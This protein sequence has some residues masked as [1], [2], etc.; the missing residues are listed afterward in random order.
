MGHGRIPCAV[1]GP[2]DA[3]AI[4]L[5]HANGWSRA[6][7]HAQMVALAGEFRV[8][9]PDL[10]GHGAL[11]AVP[12]TLDG[13]VAALDT[14]IGEVAGG[15]AVVVGL[16]LGG[17]VAMAHAAA[18][19]GQVAGLALCGCSVAF[20]GRLRLLTQ[21]TGALYDTLYTPRWGRRLV[22][23]QQREAAAAYPP[24][25]IGA[26]LADGFYPRY[27]GRALR[28]MARRDFRALLRGYDG[29]VVILNGERDHHNR[30]AEDE[31][32]RA[33]RDA[34]IAVIRDAGHLTNLDQ[35]EAFTAAVRLFARQVAAPARMRPDGVA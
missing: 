21:L 25:V 14:V 22:A 2:P 35:P 20:R 29:P 13:A 26:Q 10:P 3:P 4:V 28:Q 8:I 12:F 27:W 32:A 15:R 23:K 19:P 33:A 34:P 6:M 31:Q 18:H 9:A 17:Y 30:E 11:A 24:A 7:W 1:A 5:L 16:S